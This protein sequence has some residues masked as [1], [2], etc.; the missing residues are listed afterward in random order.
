MMKTVNFGKNCRVQLHSTRKPYMELVR[1]RVAQLE[2][3]VGCPRR[4][5]FKTNKSMMTGL[6]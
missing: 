5:Y 4:F 1:E 3:Q 6:R 2:L